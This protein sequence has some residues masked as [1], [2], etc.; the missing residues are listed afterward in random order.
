VGYPREH[1][2][3]GACTEHARFARAQQNDFDGRMLETEPLER[4]R[5]LDVHSEVIR[6]ELELVAFEQRA[7]LVH[8]HQQRGDFAIDPELP[9]PISRR[10]G[11][12]IDPRLAVAQLALCIGH[13]ILASAHD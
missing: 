2:D 13:L 12:E 4:V 7:L 5:E 11:L 8:V 9:V 3:I 10:L 6:V 1:A